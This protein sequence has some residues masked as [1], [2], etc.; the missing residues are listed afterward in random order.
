MPDG[1]LKSSN[2]LRQHCKERGLKYIRHNGTQQPARQI[3]EACTCRKLC[4]MKFMD[5]VRRKLLA[6]LLGLS[7]NG[8]FIF[9]SSHIE[10]VAVQRPRFKYF[11]RK[12]V[13]IYF[14]PYNSGRIQVC[15]RMF[16][17]TYDITDKRLRLLNEKIHIGSYGEIVNKFTTNP[18]DNVVAAQPSVSDYQEEAGKL[19]VIFYHLRI[20][21]LKNCFSI[22]TRRGYGTGRF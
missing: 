8:Q 12:S 4:Y 21:P 18:S 6:N 20:Y 7:A 9:L 14:L 15:M 5:D 22:R 17:N 3:K 10:R 16:A 2:A 1:S 11:P 19:L 13:R